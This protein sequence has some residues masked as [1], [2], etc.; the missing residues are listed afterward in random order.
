[1]LL[2]K[3]DRFYIKNVTENSIRA[4]GGWPDD[5][6]HI[7]DADEEIQEI[8]WEIQNIKEMDDALALAEVIISKEKIDI[9]RLDE[10][11]ISLKTILKWND[12][13]FNRALEALLAIKVDMI[14][15]NEKTDF[16]FV[17]F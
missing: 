5:G 9:N 13:R 4:I 14:D 2:F 12:I 16:F 7:Y 8:E 17:H 3:I 11:V 6:L 10:D 15:D 1:M